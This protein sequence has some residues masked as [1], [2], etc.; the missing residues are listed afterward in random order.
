MA[1]N[2]IF[3]KIISGE[4]PSRR[5]YEN[6]RVLAFDDINPMAPV[7]VIIIP[8]QH[9]P[10]LLDMT[11][12]NIDIMGD[13]ISAVREVSRIKGVDQKGFRTVINCNEEGGQVIFHLHLH[14]LGGTKLRDDL[15]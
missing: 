7:H 1:E 12:E 13:I 5:V 6:D 4:I 14:L 10:T 8:K 11:P 2:C 3:C 15:G 9:I